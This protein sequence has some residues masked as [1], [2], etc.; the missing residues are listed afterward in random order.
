MPS[1]CA[2]VARRTPRPRHRRAV[3]PQLARCLC[4]EGVASIMM[5]DIVGPYDV[6]ADVPEW[7]WV[8]TNASFVHRDNGTDGVWD[9]MVNVTRSLE[10]APKRLRAVLELARRQ[11]VSLLL[12]HQGC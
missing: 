6:P 12:F 10:G 5:Q 2:I 1:S 4:I 9:Y 8:Q 7:A 11:G 3:L